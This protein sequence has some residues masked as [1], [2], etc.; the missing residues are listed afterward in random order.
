MLL[1]YTKSK[2]ADADIQQIVLRS[3]ADFG[4]GQT[5]RYIS[6]LA[7]SLH[8]VATRPEL[9]RSFIHEPT[10]QVYRRYRYESHMIYYRERPTDVL[11]VRILHTKMLP[12]KHL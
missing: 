2:R 4:D 1:K 3:L 9:G 10:G 5:D 8:T 7:K 12:E 11:I 6:G